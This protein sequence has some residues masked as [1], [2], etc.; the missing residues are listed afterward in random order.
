M[1][2]LI[3]TTDESRHW[4]APAQLHE[5]VH[6]HAVPPEDVH[7]F[8]RGRNSSNNQGNSGGERSG[9]PMVD[10]PEEFNRT[11]ITWIENVT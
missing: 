9:I 8:I 11:V 6:L 4:L 10:H 1:P 3:A 2:T 7:H 5:L